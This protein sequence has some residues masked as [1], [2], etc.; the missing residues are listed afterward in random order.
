MLILGAKGHASEILD[1]LH[2]QNSDL[3]FFDNVSTD[4]G[5]RLFNKYPVFKT[6]EEVLFRFKSDNRF[7]LG[8]G[9]PKTRHFLA[10]MFR[11]WGGELTSVISETALIGS[12]DVRLGAG[13]NIMHNVIISND[14]NIGEGTLVNAAA[15]IHHNAV[16][17]K[18]CEISPGARVLGEVELGDFCSI[19]SNAILLPKIKIG[20]NVIV[21]AGAVV[22]RNI[23]DNTTVVGIP[24]R[25]PVNSRNQ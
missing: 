23:E 19:G 22:T 11:E 20:N 7:A 6:R 15:S 5:N 8:V 13:L 21:G 14:V 9:N 18:Y 1:V 17:G 2:T 3:C 16:V 24:A 4:I 10:Q 25:I 12:F